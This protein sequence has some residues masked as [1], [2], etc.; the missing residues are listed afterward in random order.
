MNY[1]IPLVIN[2]AITATPSFSKVLTLQFYLMTIKDWKVQ[3]KPREKLATLGK[4]NLKDEELLAIIINTG[5]PKISAVTTAKKIIKQFTSSKNFPNLE[6]LQTV[7]GVGFA[8]ACQITA[9]FELGRRFYS[10]HQSELFINTP[11]DI[12]KQV[13]DIRNKHREYLVALY[14]DGQTQLIKK[15]VISIGGINQNL[16]ETKDV[17][18]EAVRLPCV[19]VAIAHNHPSGN[20]QP[21]DQDTIFTKTLKRAGQILGITLVDHLIVTKDGYYSFRENKLV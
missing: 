2:K 11:K 8:K 16:V 21:S 15:Q 9:A 6:K 5:Q 14:L 12:L 4:K 7:K 20:P 17:F 19:A 1:Y 18:H 13:S 3:Q 10:D